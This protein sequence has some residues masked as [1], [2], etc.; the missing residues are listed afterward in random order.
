MNHRTPI[1]WIAGTSILTLGLALA[2]CGGT[3]QASSANGD[4][5]ICEGQTVNIGVVTSASDAPFFIADAKGY[6]KDAGVDVNFESFDSAA[7][8]I[9]PLGS[10]ALDVG[11]GAPSAGFYNAV[12]RDVNIKIVADKGTM[13]EGFSYMPLMVRKDLVD[14]GTVKSVADLRGLSVAEPA[15]STATASTLSTMLAAEDL[16]YDDVSHEYIGFGEHLAAF[17]N[18]GIDA[19]LTTEPNAT[20]LENEGVAVRF[21]D[22]TVSYPDQQLAVVLYADRFSQNKELG[23][24]VMTAYLKGVRDYAAAMDEDGRMSGSQADEVVKI[25]TEATGVEEDLYRKIVL[26]YIHPEGKVNK[27]SLQK[28]LD[29]FTN[30]GA[31]EGAEVEVESIIDDSFVKSAGTELEAPSS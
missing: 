22:P 21:A 31:L 14:N 5:T 2:A 12:S 7:K 18:G 1:R 4:A 11:G 15:Q 9:A 6:F 24:C 29:F 30:Q 23:T 25:V 20:R 19:A 3:G 13:A 28:D 10:G 17:S 8:M 16:T 27:E 26:N